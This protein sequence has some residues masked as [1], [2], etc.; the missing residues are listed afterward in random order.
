VQSAEINRRFLAFFEARGHTV[1]PSASLI[2]DD[3]T[4]LLVNAGMV[5][6]EPY[7]LGREPAPYP[8]AT[9]IQ[10]CART[11]DIDEVGNTTRHNTFFQ[12][13]GNFSFGD[14]FKDGAIPLAWE[15]LTSSVEEGGFGFNPD[16]L[17]AT[18]Y[19][20]DDEAARIWTDVVGLPAERVQRRGKAD[21]YWSMGVP[22][23]CGPNSEIY[24]DRGPSYG[25]EG[26]PVV[27]EERYLEV[28]NLVFMQYE[29][30]AGSGK[31]DWPIL[32]ELPAKN[33]DTGMGVE[34][35]ATILQGVD[36]VYET[37]LLRPIL[38]RAATLAGASYGE[39]HDT[40][41]RLR[42]V[43]DHTRTAVMLVGDGVMPSNEGRGYVLRRLLRRVVRSMRLLSA[44]GAEAPGGHSAEQSS[45][46]ELAAAARDCMSPSYPE[47]GR[48]FA[49]IEATILAEEE[50]FGATLRAG[51]ARFDE[52]ASSAR[53]AGRRQITG[54]EAFTLH[55]TYGFPVEL[56]LEMAAEQG[57]SV[58]EK[59]FARLMTEQRDRAKADAAA[60]KTGHVDVAV[61]R[62]LLDEAG[63]S[64]FTGYSAVAGEATVRGLLVGG[65]PA[66]AAGEGA[67]VEVVLDRTPFYAE[68]GG[69]LADQGMIRLADGTV[70]EVDDVQRP[71]GD[72][73]V[74]RARVVSGE[75]VVGEAAET[76]VEVERRRAISRAHTAT[77]L[78]HRAV[79]GALGEQAAQAGSLNAP[80]RLRFDFSAPGA[81]PQSVL[82]DVEEE[83][84]AVL[85]GDLPVRAFVTSQDE[86]RR[87]GAL[88]LFGEKYGDQVRV[89]EVGDYARELCGGTHVARSGQLGLVKLLGES[90]IGAG[91]RRVEALVGMDAFRF[92]AREHLL[93]TQL[94]DAMKARPEELSQRV[95]ESLS[96]LRAAE[97]ELER[98][99]AGAVLAE[100][101][102]LATAA[103]NEGTAAMVTHRAPDGTVGDDLRKLALDVR[104]RLEPSRPAVVAVAAADGTTGA[105]GGDGRA[106]MVVAVNEAGRTA[107][108]AAGALVKTAAGVLGGGGG[109][110]DDVAQGGG[111]RADAIDDAFAALRREVAVRASTH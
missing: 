111:G 67:A 65:A 69:Q 52:A 54:G 27:D 15:L 104:G 22:G 46:G 39:S 108:L 66:R 88:A 81:V 103:G 10:K 106:S 68:A 11:P 3:P 35:M 26:G 34:R 79:R 63:P 18:V 94:A 24:Y 12:M 48:D 90:S 55:D 96:R 61:Y 74:H 107:G 56:T 25:T 101:P 109:G 30:G 76:S 49:R 47:V 4:L 13:A 33:V 14:Y 32:G 1:E 44:E 87:I 41:V 93:V 95:E 43:A 78:V 64:T 75:A 72:L 29:R 23:P 45:L 105:A 21:N 99:R 16:R 20:D 9:S 58:D 50:S 86:A 62:S 92:L 82:A 38:D 83:V 71:V 17:W 19:L 57:L 89:V 98:L 7:F 28:W 37:D 102:R 91:T 40:D 84:N 59:G 97:R 5:P 77:H 42:V 85:S 73:I 100:A 60:K 6:F 8:R 2:L 51:S 36:N 80:G 53:S 110:R 70:L 31:E